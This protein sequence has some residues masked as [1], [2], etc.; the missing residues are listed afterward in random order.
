MICRPINLTNKDN[1]HLKKYIVIIAFILIISLLGCSNST[2]LKNGND[3]WE[4]Q[5]SGDKITIERKETVSDVSI[6]HFEVMP[7]GNEKAKVAANGYDFKDD[8]ITTSFS[9][10]EHFPEDK[11]IIVIIKWDNHKDTIELKR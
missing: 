4:V 10:F 7:K 9:A 8:N 2:I 1:I 11:N 3:R 6:I 5:I